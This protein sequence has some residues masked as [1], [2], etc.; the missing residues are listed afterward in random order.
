MTT[1]KL[2]NSIPP[3]VL[4]ALITLPVFIINIYQNVLKHHQKT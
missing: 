3:I 1:Q 2:K 4:F